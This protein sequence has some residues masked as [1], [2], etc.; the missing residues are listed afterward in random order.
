MKEVLGAILDD[1]LFFRL[2]AISSG[3]SIANITVRY[4]AHSLRVEL[5]G[6]KV[7][8]FTLLLKRHQ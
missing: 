8:D 1:K 4:H 7:L 6:V 5:F 3:R 2:D